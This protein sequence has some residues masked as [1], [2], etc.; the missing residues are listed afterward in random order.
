MSGNEYLSVG[1]SLSS[2]NGRFELGFFRPGQS[3][4][5]YI[6]IWFK[7]ISPQTVV[8]V[9]NRVTPIS[10]STKLKILDGN[11][12]LVADGAQNP[13]WS[14]N[15]TAGAAVL[16]TL[17]DNGNLVLSDGG[18][19]PIWQSFDH[20]T[21]TYLPG[22][23]IGY[24]KRTKTKQVF[25]SW[26]D[27]DDP[28]P[29][30]FSFDNNGNMS[31]LLWNGTEEYWNSGPKF[32]NGTLRYLKPNPTFNFTIIDNENESY[33]TFTIKTS[34]ISRFVIDI[35]G[36]HK[37]L[38]WLESTQEWQS[39]IAEPSQECDVYAHCGPFSICSQNSSP[40]CACLY[41]FEYKSQNAL[42]FD[43]CVRKTRFKCEDSFG[44]K[45][46]PNVRLPRH[47]QNITTENQAECESTCLNNCSC[48][49]YAY[50][51]HNSNG[52]RCSLWIG[53]LLNL[54]QFDGNGSTIYIRL[55]ASEF[56]NVE[57]INSRHLSGKLKAIIPTVAVVA[58]ALLAFTIFYVCYRRRTSL[59]ITE[60]A[61][62]AMDEM[63]DEDSDE[64][65]IGV[66]FF[67]F[68]SISEATDN[69]LDAN[70]L[71]K[72]GFGTVYKGMLPGG[73]EIAVKRLSNQSRQGIDEFKN[74]IVLIAKL[75]HRNLVKLI[76]YYCMQAGEKILIYEHMAN[77]SL[78][79][80]IFNQTRRLLLD[81]TKRFDI[82]LGIVRGL[83][84][85]HHDSRLRIIHRDMKT[86]NILLDEEMTPKISDFGLARMV[87]GNTFEANT[88]KVAGTYGYMSPEYALSGL[89]STKSDVFSF[90][91]IILEIICG[92]KNTS[93]YQHEEVS[94]LLGY[95][96]KL[97]NEGNAMDLLDDSLLECCK[98]CEVL[99]CIN[100][101]LLCVEE[102]PNRRPSMPIV[103]LMLTDES[104]NLPKPNQ[105]AFVTRNH[106][107]N[108]SSTIESDKLCS[109]Q[110]T[111]SAQEG[112]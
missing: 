77:R 61:V 56:S 42:F 79:T 101:G 59:K 91:V 49:A 45:M 81:W 92:K 21:N 40:V 74:E 78:D 85:L 10:S 88:K 50:H 62:E 14:T 84:Y 76:G 51:H 24:N 16:A 97:W 104:M 13:V 15:I 96:W 57:D 94:N 11:L 2:S 53:Q 70:I 105:P 6:G 23:K 66:Q 8:W 43:G 36:Q 35:N 1:M 67:T 32:G 54:K 22:S 25:T 4:N 27:L 30:L 63:I 102:D 93:F 17:G 89:F 41:G 107:C 112:R 38:A 111:F 82:I 83:V 37:S 99:K 48:T 9:A 86:N 39:M 12:A 31:F 100:V 103:F 52:S 29:G 73:Q 28:A 18:A 58:A 75:Q 44:F 98:E 72:G 3:S 47:P 65:G 33:F 64:N 55:A 34:L 26:K 80:F 69:F 71:G 108:D 87:V 5:Y 19:K 109:N 7:N 46:Y 90:G 110:L 68:Q 106:I 60:R 95:A 20:P